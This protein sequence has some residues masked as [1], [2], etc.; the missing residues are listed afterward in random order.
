SWSSGRRTRDPAR[1]AAA[2]SSS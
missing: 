2:G 1:C